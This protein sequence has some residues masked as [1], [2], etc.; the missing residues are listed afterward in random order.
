[1]AKPIVNPKKWTRDDYRLLVVLFLVVIYPIFAASFFALYVFILLPVMVDGNHTIHQAHQD[2]WYQYYWLFA[3]LLWLLLCALI[4]PCFWDKTKKPHHEIAMDNCESP[5]YT[6]KPVAVQPFV[7]VEEGKEKQRCSIMTDKSQNSCESIENETCEEKAEKESFEKSK[8]SLQKS[9]PSF[10][11]REKLTQSGEFLNDFIDS[12]ESEEL[13]KKEAECEVHAEENKDNPNS[14]IQN[15]KGVDSDDDHN[16]NEDSVTQDESSESSDKEDENIPQRY[17][18]KNNDKVTQENLEKKKMGISCEDLPEAIDVEP[19]VVEKKKENQQEAVPLHVNE[20]KTTES[21]LPEGQ[22]ET[23]EFDEVV[24]PLRQKARP[25]IDT[26]RASGY[27]ECSMP[28]PKSAD[29]KRPESNMVFLFVNPETLSAEEGV[30]VE[31]AGEV[32]P[33]KQE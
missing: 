14:G 1:M 22:E 26:S 8:E 9:C 19:I 6:T 17:T 20:E 18:G 5:S 16:A 28:T 25:T 29:L 2:G 15:K 21:K 7:R 3:A 11:E 12:L 33:E 13:K 24:P 27:Y 10:D 32:H 4:L 23:Q 30:L 31:H